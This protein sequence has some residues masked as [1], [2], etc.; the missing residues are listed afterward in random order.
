MSIIGYARVSTDGQ[1]LQ[2][3]TE[4]LHQ[5]GAA[6]VYSE[7]Q[8][9]AYTDRPQLAKAIDRQEL[10]RVSYDHCEADGLTNQS[11]GATAQDQARALVL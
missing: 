3:Q 9:G 5:S 6:K 2:S 8:S 4:A 10:Q 11:F 7:K 1:S